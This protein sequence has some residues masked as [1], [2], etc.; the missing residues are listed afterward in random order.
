MKRKNTFNKLAPYEYRESKRLRKLYHSKI[1]AARKRKMMTGDD[2]Q[3]FIFESDSELSNLSETSESSSEYSA[4]S[5]ELE[6]ELEIENTVPVD[7]QNEFLVQSNETDINNGK[8]QIQAM[9]TN[10]AAANQKSRKKVRN[11][12]DNIE[13][14]DYRPSE[15]LNRLSFSGKPVCSIENF[16]DDPLH[17][18]ELIVTKEI[19]QKIATEKNIC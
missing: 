12:C 4:I 3:N 14:K 6:E 9:T 2:V 17:I 7:L 19:F 1:M 15:G 11:E 10:R 18:Y 5:E 13:W 8:H 16:S